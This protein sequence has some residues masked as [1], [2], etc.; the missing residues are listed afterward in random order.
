MYV[1][2]CGDEEKYFSSEM[3]ECP[4]LFD[5]S[6]QNLL[7]IQS[8]FVSNDHHHSIRIDPS[9]TSETIIFIEKFD[10]DSLELHVRY[11]L[12]HHHGLQTLKCLDAMRKER[13]FCD[14]ILTVEGHELFAHRALLVCHSNYFL[15]LFQR[16]ENDLASKKQ[17]YYQID[18]LGHEALKLILQFI[19]QGR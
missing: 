11:E 15:D 12:P 3:K 1:Y 14:V 5:W 13:Q 6:I 8:V 19:Y 18:G 2:A 4:P 17:I 10:P 9:M 7:S 16:D